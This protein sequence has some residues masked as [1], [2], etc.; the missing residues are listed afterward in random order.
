LR[1]SYRC[2]IPANKPRILRASLDVLVVIGVRRKELEERVL[3]G[4]NT[5]R[6]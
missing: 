5:C 1:R 2:D 3:A 4:R 6:D